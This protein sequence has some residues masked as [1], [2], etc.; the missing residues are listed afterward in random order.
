MTEPGWSIEPLTSPADID[1]ILAI[2][3]RSFTNPW[4]R[5]M[6]LAELKNTGTSFFLLARDQARQVIAF[7]AYWRVVD[8]LHINNIAVVPE[9][10]QRG[11]AKAL[12]ARAIDDGRR[13]GARSAMLEVRRSNLIAIKLYEGIGFSIAGVRAG[14]YTKPDEDGLVLRLDPLTSG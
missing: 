4:T 7:C 3:E 11:I 10:R 8:E 12:L 5:D 9:W 1:A 6:Y 14:Y 2:E 13:R